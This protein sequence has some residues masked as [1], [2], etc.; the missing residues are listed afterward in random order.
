MEPLHL[1]P[2]LAELERIQRGET[3]HVVCHTP[4][5]GGKTETLLAAVGWLLRGH[6][7]WEVGYCSYNATQ[8]RSK[9]TRGRGWASDMG[10]RWVSEAVLES[11]TAQGGGLLARG[12]G[13]G[14]TGQG[15]DVAIVDD[16]HKDRAE[17]E[18]SVRRQ[19]VIDWFNDVLW[20]RRNPSVGSKRPQSIIVNMARW[21]PDDLAGTLIKQGWRYICLP[22]LATVS[23]TGELVPAALDDEKQRSFWPGAWSPEDLRKTRLQIGEYSFASL[24]QGQPRPR[25]GAV[26]GDTHLWESRPVEFDVAFGLDAAYTKWTASDWSV[27]V[28]LARTRTKQPDGTYVV[29]YYVLDVLR[30]QVKLPEFVAAVNRLAAKYGGAPRMRWYGSSTEVGTADLARDMENGLPRLRG[31]RATEDKHARAQPVAAAWN[32]GDVLVPADSQQHLWVSTFV[33]EVVAFTGVADK[34][35]DQVDALAAAFDEL[36]D[37]VGRVQRDVKTAPPEGL[38]AREL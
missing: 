1:A 9:A 5:R 38:R 20:T 16:P 36:A 10:V 21:H 4:P 30:L 14:L 6:P 37:E 25:G 11:R 31:L 33:A 29:K 2:L 28:V 7:D 13:E 12:V 24:Y 15:L 8:A 23:P 22:A 18:S 27:C 34:H 19:R 3:V 35:D 32:R 26:F 17:A